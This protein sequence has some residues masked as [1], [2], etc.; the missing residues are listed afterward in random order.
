MGLMKRSKFSDGQIAVALRQVDEGIREGA[1]C[2]K[3]G[4]CDNSITDGGP[5][6]AASC[7]R[8]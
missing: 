2:R 6:M 7:P 5:S 1:I 3:L 4:I 8:T